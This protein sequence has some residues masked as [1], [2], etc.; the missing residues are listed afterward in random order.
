MCSAPG[1]L[2]VVGPSSDR[3]QVLTETG[4]PSHCRGDHRGE[5]MGVANYME[6][7][8]GQRQN[9]YIWGRYVYEPT[10]IL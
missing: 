3:A 9:S 6:E 10:R 7:H 1:V 5:N 4:L 8:R 2:C